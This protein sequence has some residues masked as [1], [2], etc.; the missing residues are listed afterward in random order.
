[1][2]F[3]SADILAAT[4]PVFALMGLGFWFRRAGWIEAA[5]D[6]SLLFLTVNVTYP[7]LILY[8]ILGDSALR[9][10][11]NVWL[12][13]LCGAGF[14]AV[15]IG[16]GWLAAPLFGLRQPRSRNTFALACSVQNYGYLPIPILTAL[17]PGDGW[18]GIL[19]IY[20]LG[21]ELV[22]WTLGVM[23]VSGQGLGAV[24]HM[25][26]PVVLSIL[27]GV[28]LNFAGA[29]AHCPRWLHSVIVTLGDSSIPLGLLI[30]GI[31]LADLTRSPGWHRDW[32]T[33]L[34]GVTLRLA[35][36]PLMMLAVAKFIAPGPQFRHVLAVQ[37]A[38]PAAVFPMILARRYGGDETTAMRVIVVTTLVSVA[39]I[40]FVVRWALAWLG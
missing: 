30:V 27:L 7:S 13:A 21:I 34:G 20:S 28:G 35:L 29:G 19:F 33:P 18:A 1:M 14:M 38:M 40:P 11:V 16:L 2:H 6:R 25:I 31:T 8:K 39:T 15:G 5:A 26:N 4:L 10:P 22:L 23:M 32:R 12:P 17:F 9:D 36:L 37:A 3:S 24:R